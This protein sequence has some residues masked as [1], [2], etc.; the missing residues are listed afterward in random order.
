MEHAGASFHLCSRGLLKE[1][2]PSCLLALPITF[3]F[4]LPHAF[5][6]GCLQANIMVGLV[7]DHLLH[8]EA[9][10]GRSGPNR[11]FFNMLSWVSSG[12]RGGGS[13]QHVEQWRCGKER[14]PWKWQGEGRWRKGAAGKAGQGREK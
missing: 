6:R 1:C 13:I 8:M 9:V 2:E 5:W 3:L 4:A 10:T 11:I 12:R 7:V 14:S